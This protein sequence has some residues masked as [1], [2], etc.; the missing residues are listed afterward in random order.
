MGGW[1]AQ[2]LPTTQLLHTHTYHFHQEK[3]QNMWLKQWEDTGKGA[4][5]K[6]FFP[7]VKSRL[8]TEIPVFPELT[9]IVTGHGE[10]KVIS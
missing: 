7:S 9:S 8:R 10:M 4:V 5:T 2:E 1:G 3:R 6:A